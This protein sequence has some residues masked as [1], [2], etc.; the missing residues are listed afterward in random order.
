MSSSPDSAQVITI[1]SARQES[2]PAAPLALS[3]ED[4]LEGKS[5][6]LIREI[7]PSHSHFPSVANCSQKP[8]TCHSLQ[9]H[10]QGDLAQVL[11]R[12]I[13]PG[14]VSGPKTGT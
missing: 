10:T 9:A 4:S 11:L 7:H 12:T 8:P 13:I 14:T 3:L 5:V 2:H 1:A 6:C